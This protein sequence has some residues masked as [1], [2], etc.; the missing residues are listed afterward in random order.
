[1]TEKKRTVAF[2]VKPETYEKIKQKNAGSS[3]SK[4]AKKLVLDAIGVSE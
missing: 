4:T 3:V 1:M 2:I